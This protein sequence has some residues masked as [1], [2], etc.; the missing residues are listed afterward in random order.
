[1]SGP[2]GD[3][4]PETHGARGSDA[5]RVGRLASAAGARGLTLVVSGVPT[6]LAWALMS[7]RLDA[8]EFAGVALALSLPNVSS[9]I[10]PAMGAGIANS[11]AVGP[12]AFHDAVTRS[13]RSCAAVG[14][15]LVMTSLAVAWVG[16][17]RVLGRPEPDPFPMNAAVVF[18]SLAIALWLMLLIGERVLIALGEVTRRVWANALTGPLTLLGVIV[19]GV[20]NMP[21]WAYVLPV[22]LAMLA[23]AAC[24][25]L[26]A[27]RLP[28]VQPGPILKDALR[29]RSRG[30]ARSTLT[31]WLIVVEASLIVPIWMLRPAVS[32][33]GGAA[34]VAGLSVALQFATPVFS[35]LAVLGQTLWPYYARHR[36]TLHRRDILRH[37]ATLGAVAGALAMCYAGGLWL[38]GHWELVGH[39]PRLHLLV[40][41]GIYIL[42]RGSWEPARIVFSTNSTSRG[43]ALICTISAG[44][45][46]VAMWLVAG[47]GHGAAAVL[48]VALAFGIDAVVPTM[49]LTSRLRSGP[50]DQAIGDGA[51]MQAS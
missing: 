13:I 33:Q 50:R 46:I 47:F 42:A 24:S 51:A 2:P 41:M 10:L 22:P 43:L 49:R 44:A 21:H 19:V 28:T 30:S 11:V 9:F 37:C 35:V 38:L 26:L 32:V 20:A 27:A 5:I 31:I 23:S 16:W 1:M 39:V 29:G 25:L 45:A 14:T 18:V 8:T 36:G 15:A 7:K 48:A 3:G 6:V 12:D 17:S 4:A 34:D 40:A